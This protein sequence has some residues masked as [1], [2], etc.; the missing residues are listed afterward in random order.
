[1]TKHFAFR[2]AVILSGMLFGFTCTAS[3]GCLA[4]SSVDY[5][6]LLNS[7]GNTA[8]VQKAA[9]PGLPYAEHQYANAQLRQQINDSINRQLAHVHCVA[10]LQK[11][12]PVIA[13]I[14][15]DGSIRLGQSRQQQ[16]LAYQ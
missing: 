3:A 11:N 4:P 16:Q 5:S 9:N 7:A 13:S 14:N 10:S 2:S 6:A 8:Y 15:T 1:M 12:G